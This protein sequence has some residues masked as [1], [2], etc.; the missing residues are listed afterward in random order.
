MSAVVKANRA[1]KLVQNLGRELFQTE[2]SA[3]LHCRREADRLG[4]APP[5]QALRA[6]AEHA[7]EVLRELPALAAQS[8]I[9]DSKGGAFV[10]RVFSEIRDKVADRI[11]ESERSYRGTLLGARHGI[12]VVHLLRCVAE[13]SGEQR[14]QNFCAEWLERRPALVER[15]A[16][17]L[18][19]FARNPQVATSLSSGVESR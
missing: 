6:V 17:E 12:D 7:D 1:Q 18:A 2:R 5:G 3:A 9:P 10:G 11:I 19:W 4:S 13:E 16:D 15:V 8:S 14:L